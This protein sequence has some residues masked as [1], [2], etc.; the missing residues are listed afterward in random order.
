MLITVAV[1]DWLFYR[2]KTFDAGIATSKTAPTAVL[3]SGRERARQR[4]SQAD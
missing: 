1:S 2:L 3:Q 4:F